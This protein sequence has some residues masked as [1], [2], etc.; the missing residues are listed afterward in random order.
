MGTSS[1]VGFVEQNTWKCEKI[2]TSLSSNVLILVPLFLRMQLISSITLES[3]IRT[4]E[5]TLV[6]TVRRNVRQGTLLGDI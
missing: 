3:S 6:N 1:V 4:K 5:L 2:E